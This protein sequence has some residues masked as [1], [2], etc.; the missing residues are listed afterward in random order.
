MRIRSAPSEAGSGVLGTTFGVAVV[1]TLLM[2]AAHVLLGLWI[3]STVTAAA[4]DAALDV[5]L[6]G[7]T[8]ARRAELE[9]HAI[10]RARQSLGRYGARVRLE[11]EPTGPDEV[12]LHVTAPEVR[13]LPPP[14]ARAVGLGG[15]DRR[16][17]VQTEDPR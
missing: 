12:V 4:H 16:I 17:V 15:L 14:A 8:G 6:S 7:A 9:Q 10:A 5:A 3:T 2:F 11:F 13:L 1:V